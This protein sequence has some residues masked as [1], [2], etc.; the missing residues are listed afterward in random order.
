MIS[1]KTSLTT[2]FPLYGLWQFQTWIW[3]SQNTN[4]VSWIEHWRQQHLIFRK[5]YEKKVK[6][7]FIYEGFLSI[8]AFPVSSCHH[9]W[10]MGMQI[11][12][13]ILIVLVLSVG[14]ITSEGQSV[15]FFI[16]FI[17][18]QFLRHNCYCRAGGPVA[19]TH[20]GE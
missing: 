18:I 1:G 14:K 11:I 2:F 15:N 10:T 4:V 8:K 20:P 6:K 9:F 17:R 7:E 12:L 19:S 13:K 16:K 5:V 3:K